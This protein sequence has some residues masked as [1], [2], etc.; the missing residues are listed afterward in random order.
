[1]ATFDSTINF[2]HLTSQFP[3]IVNSFRSALISTNHQTIGPAIAAAY[4]RTYTTTLKSTNNP[5]NL[6]TN[7]TA[8][9]PTYCTTN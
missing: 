7:N 2:S 1:M 3:T 9:K 4:F 6:L 8:I 5:T